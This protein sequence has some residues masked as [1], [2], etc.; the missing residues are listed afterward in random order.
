MKR[1]LKKFL[2]FILVGFGVLYLSK[3]DIL[4]TKGLIYNENKSNLNKSDKLSNGNNIN[5]NKWI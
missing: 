1:G 2:I 5:I 4:F 3:S